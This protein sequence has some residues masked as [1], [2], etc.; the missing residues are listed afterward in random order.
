M[1]I[2]DAAITDTIMSVKRRVFC[3][4]RKMHVRRQRLVF[5]EG[6]YGMDSLADN[7]TLGGAGVLKDGA[8]LDVL[9]A[10]LSDLDVAQLGTEV[11]Q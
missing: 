3:L 5:T 1:T 11:N 8:K 7:E 2:K 10:D 4:N 9:M 6:P